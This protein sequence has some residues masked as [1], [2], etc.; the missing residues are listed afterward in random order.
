MAKPAHDWH[1]AEWLRTLG[2]RQK[3]LVADLDWNKAKASLMVNGQQKYTRDEVNE[4]SAYLNIQPFELLMH[5]EDAMAY[6][7]LRRAAADMVQI[8]FFGIA[9][10]DE[11]LTL[12]GTEG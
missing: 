6:R 5:P 2:K 8:P 12:T 7:R 1:L 11:A 3:D 9:T 10:D 4:L